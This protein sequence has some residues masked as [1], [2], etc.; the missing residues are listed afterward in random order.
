ML[1]L[2][3][4]AGSCSLLCGGFRRSLDRPISGYGGSRRAASL[5]F[6]PQQ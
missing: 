5:S 2:V 4:V 1:Q 6:P 3:A